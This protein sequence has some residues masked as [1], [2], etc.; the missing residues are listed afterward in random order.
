MKDTRRLLLGMSLGCLLGI[1]VSGC[2]TNSKKDFY[3][4]S[5]RQ[6]KIPPT[7]GSISDI[8]AKQE[9]KASMKAQ[10]AEQKAQNKA[11]KDEKSGKLKPV[12]VVVQYNDQ[13]KPTGIDLQ[14]S[15]GNDQADQKAMERVYTKYKFP[16]G[17][18]DMEV[19]TID[20]GILR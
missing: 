12:I 5:D 14:Q 3:R 11:K 2:Q 6:D 1:V 16:V 8:K 4:A 7:T 15:S 10:K 17:K 13:G 20:P 18:A 19:I 9:A